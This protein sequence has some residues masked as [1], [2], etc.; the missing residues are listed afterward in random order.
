MDALRLLVGIVM[1]LNMLVGCSNSRC[2]AKSA[3]ERLVEELRMGMD[4]V[5]EKP[6]PVCEPV[7]ADRAFVVCTFG[8]FRD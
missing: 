4:S 6:L 7:I 5:L 8:K 3:T 2:V 1:G